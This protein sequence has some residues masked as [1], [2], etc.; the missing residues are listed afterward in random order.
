MAWLAA[1]M[2][3][4]APLS[5]AQARGRRA[6]P[7]LRRDAQQWTEGR[8][9]IRKI[10]LPL[11][12]HIATEQGYPVAAQARIRRWVRRAN[13]EL[14]PYGIE[15]HVRS[16]RHL[17]EGF[18]TVTR[19]RQRRDLAQYAPRDGTI[20]VFVVEELDTRRSRVFRRRIRGL[21][22]RYRGLKRDLR[23]R[24]YVMVTRG[25]PTTTFA[26]E[27]GHLFGLRHSA[28]KDNIMCS[29]R[30]GSSISF[31][32]LQGDDMRQG[33]RRFSMR[34]QDGPAWRADRRGR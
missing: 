30:E 25:A 16:I 33:A 28:R 31:S 34:Q 21:H 27:L 3:L 22:W 1:W 11:T 8:R 4:L 24:E 15:V 18:A 7:D 6:V 13:E 17:P 5:V 14:A 26:H 12:L 32:S 10:R 23:S 9:A 29:C 2:M 19:W 20:H